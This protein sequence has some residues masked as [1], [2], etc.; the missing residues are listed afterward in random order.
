MS[1]TQQQHE[2][3]MHLGTPA[4][5]VAGAG[6]GKT[7]TLT[8]KFLHLIESGYDPERILA[9][10]FTNKAA[11]EMK[12]RLIDMTGFGLSR[13][14]WVRTYHSA[15]LQILKKHYKLA[16]FDS[17]PQIY[18]PYQQ[19]KI[20]KEILIQKNYDKKHTRPVLYKLSLAK[21]SANPDAY[22]DENPTHAY[23]IPLAEIYQSY[24]TELLRASAVDFDNILLITRNLLK[25]HKSV[26]QYYQNLFRYVLVDEYQDTNNLQ[27]ELTSLLTSNGN[28]FCVGDD[29]QAI[30][31]F[32]GSN[33][34]H[35][36]SF[37]KK[38]PGAKL[39]RLEENFRSADEIVQVA[40]QVIG[41]NEVRVDKKCFS[42][43]HGGVVEIHSFFDE[44]Q[45]AGWVASK[46]RVFHKSGIP[47][48][49]MAVLYRTK[50]CSLSFEQIFRSKDIPYQMMGGKGF[51]ERKEIL[52]LVAYLN[53]AQFEKDNISFERSI[54]IP[55]R[56]VG[57]GTLKKIATLQSGDMA[58]LEATRCAVARKVMSA[59]LHNALKSYLNLIDEI[60]LLKPAKAI[61]KVITDVNYMEHLESYT[62]GNK[63]DMTT[64]QEN[65]DQLIYS[66]SKHD[67]LIDFLEEASL[68]KEDKE[69]EDN[70]DKYGVK[71]STIHASKGLE[72]K[73]VF[74]IGCEEQL[75]PHWK[76]MESA[77]ELE[78]E[79]R[80]MYVS[81]TRAERYLFLTSAQYR[82]GQMNPKSRFL[83]EIESCL[84][85]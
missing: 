35:F 8:A 4:L 6:S 80:L 54:N 84:P 65:I 9:I 53:V 34:S 78:E 69:E 62:K 57:P 56:G 32:R 39:F 38:Y 72:Y 51:F 66:A 1:L 16:G 64:R 14:F 63:N 59:K 37:E 27:E 19:E 31:S 70:D 71:L 33:I 26:R 46:V 82:R 28:L 18:Q 15:C 24:E 11:D 74:V 44:N 10:T 17:S 47:Y 25:D 55:K 30:Y 48:D 68:V 81:M 83:Y 2:A 85:D 50:F 79:R 45:E 43:K 49:S 3:V 77:A 73:L 75:F 76:S 36:L 58:L 40:N 5:V 42:Q 60:K 52:D 21:N 67:S 12:S 41:K 23:V 29:W 22:F 61:R 13:F 7:R 20:V